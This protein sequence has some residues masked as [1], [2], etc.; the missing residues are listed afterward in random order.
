MARLADGWIHGLGLY[1]CEGDSMPTALAGW[2]EHLQESVTERNW[3][4]WPLCPEH[5][6]GLHGAELDGVAVWRCSAGPEPTGPGSVGH[7][8]APVGGLRA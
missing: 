7:T 5:S 4:V 6:I 2:A 3:T 1:P 8:V